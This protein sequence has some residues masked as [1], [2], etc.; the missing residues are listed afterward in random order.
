MQNKMS[1]K[2]AGYRDSSKLPV[3]KSSYLL[4]DI[5]VSFLLL[6]VLSPIFLVN[7]LISKK[8]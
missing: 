3:V 2:V 6:L 4:I 7:L 5:P 1:I 8:H